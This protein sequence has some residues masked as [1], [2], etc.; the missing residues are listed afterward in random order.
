M[1]QLK[2]EIPDHTASYG[3]AGAPNLLISTSFR[4]SICFSDARAQ[5]RYLQPLLY[6][7]G[8]ALQ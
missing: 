7:R 2:T 3:N 4:A 6:H 5:T 8:N 1:L